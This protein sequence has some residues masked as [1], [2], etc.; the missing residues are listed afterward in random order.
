MTFTSFKGESKK[1]TRSGFTLAEEIRQDSIRS[2]GFIDQFVFIARQSGTPGLK[3]FRTCSLPRPTPTIDSSHLSRRSS[4]D[5]TVCSSRREII[6]EY[7][8]RNFGEVYADHEAEHYEGPA[9]VISHYNNQYDLVN[10]LLLQYL[11]TGDARWFELCESLAR[12]VIDIDIYHTTQDKAAY[13][14]GMFWHTNHYRDAATSTHRAYSRHNYRPGDPFAGG[15]PSSNHNYSTGLLHYHYMTG[16]PNAREAVI[17]LA[18]WVVNMDD[19]EQSVFGIL[20]P[21]PTGNATYPGEPNYQGPCRGAGNSINVLIDGWLLTGRRAYLDKAETL[22]RRVSHPDDDIPG[23][24]LLNVEPRWS[25]T[26][27]LSSVS[28]YLS[29]K[30]EDWA[31]GLHVRLCRDTCCSVMQS[32]WLITR[33]PTSIRWR[34]SNSPTRPG[35]RRSSERLTSS[36]W[37][38]LM[39]RSRC[40]RLCSVA[41]TNWRIVPGRTSC[42][43]DSQ[44]LRTGGRLALDRG[45]AKRLPDGGDRGYGPASLPDVRLRDCGN[46]HSPEGESLG[47]IAD[48]TR[49]GRRSRSHWPTHGT[50]RRFAFEATSNRYAQFFYGTVLR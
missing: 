44:I 6:D 28:R 25:Y 37:R 10:G 13:N 20:D 17:S 46:L 3:S 34:S 11:R 26:V 14:G 16:D 27:F 18:D 22:I 38:Q 29:V 24:N 12:H 42:R 19:G 40:D 21:T 45:I 8:W 5:L 50:G 2:H 36:A 23:R 39:P 43:F 47:P 35:P 49:P 1:R 32:G 4:M 15:G 30:A 48:R 41:V 33:D 7:G 31:T 9:P